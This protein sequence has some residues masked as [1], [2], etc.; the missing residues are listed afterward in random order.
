MV[1]AGI[2]LPVDA[3]SVAIRRGPDQDVAALGEAGHGGLDLVG[4][5]RAVGAEFHADSIS[6]GAVALRVDAKSGRIGRGPGNDEAV[7]E[8]GN[9]GRTLVAGDGRVDAE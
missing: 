5:S 9:R 8:T 2:H 7:V 6:V 4:R 1:V 3:A